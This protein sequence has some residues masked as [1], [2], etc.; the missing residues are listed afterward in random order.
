MHDS[1]PAWGVPG[2]AASLAETDVTARSVSD[3]YGR[4]SLPFQSPPRPLGRSALLC[5][6]GHPPHRHR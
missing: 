4:A 3:A 5:S 2:S 6:P 1:G